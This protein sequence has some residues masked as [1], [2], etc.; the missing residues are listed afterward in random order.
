MKQIHSQPGFTLIEL[1]VVISIIA[2]L[3]SLLLPVLSSAR[4]MAHVS[5]EL[6]NLRQ[7]G[8]AVHTYGA[9]FDDALPG[10]NNGRQR[11]HQTVR[12]RLYGG[13]YLTA[14]RVTGSGTSLSFTSDLWG[15]PLSD[16]IGLS[17]ERRYTSTWFWN[18]G[19][20]GSFTE[21]GSNTLVV[22]DRGSDLADAADDPV[23]LDGRGFLNYNGSISSLVILC[24]AGY[25]P[26]SWVPGRGQVVSPGHTHQSRIEESRVQPPDTTSWMLDGHARVRSPQEMRFYN[27]VQEAWY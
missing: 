15:C 13:D 21:D 27:F 7:V 4:R 8:M 25:F 18:I 16:G 24:D 1:L 10:G 3:I 20:G 2:L 5:L 14:E 9:D 17:P 26:A 22:T 23:Y 12:N 11:D 19:V 6:S